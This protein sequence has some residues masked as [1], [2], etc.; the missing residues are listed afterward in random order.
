MTDVLV[1]DIGGTHARFAL[2]GNAGIRAE[3]VFKVADFA[4][5]GDAVTAYLKDI[6]EKPRVAAFAMAGPV[7]GDDRFELTNFNWSFSIQ[8]TRKS[9]GLD[10]LL[11][12]N[13]F[14]ALAIGVLEADPAHVHTLGGGTKKPNGNMAIIGPGTGLGVASLIWDAKDKRYVPLQCEGGHVTLP[15]KNP[16]EFAI[17]QW[18]LK[19]KYS[20][21]SA[22][23]VC[24]GKGLLNLYD[25]IRALDNLSLPD[26]EPQEIT[27]KA[28]KGECTACEECLTLLFAF[29]GRIAGNLALTTMA[30]GG[31]YLAGGILPRIGLDVLKNSAVRAEFISKGRQTPLVEDIPLFMVDDPFLALKGLRSYAMSA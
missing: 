11:L 21:V 30:T 17:Q 16:R 22:E 10:R 1:A 28:L 23:R 12:I 27:T 20:H 31:V 29:L 4:G 26:L 24:S 8:E 2:A 14:T 3:R 13:D 5:P 19:N 15:V 6:G 7:T 9:L 18:L 25:A